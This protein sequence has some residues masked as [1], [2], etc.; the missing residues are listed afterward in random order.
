MRELTEKNWTIQ[1]TEAIQFVITPPGFVNV[2]LLWEKYGIG[3]KVILSYV[4]D[5]YTHWFYWNHDLREISQYTFNLEMSQPGKI[6][7]IIN[8]WDNS[9]KK[10][11][12]HT[13]KLSSINLQELTKDQLIEE[14]QKFSKSY[15]EAWGE[16]LSADAISLYMEKILSKKLLPHLDKKG[17][18]YNYTKY[19]PTL[20]APT[21]TSFAA[22]E[23]EDLFKIALKSQRKEDIS[24]DLEEHSK[25][26][27]WLTNS[28]LRAVYLTPEF[29]KGKVEE[30]TRRNDLSEKLEQLHRS[31]LKAKEEK[32]KLC[33]ELELTKEII[34]TLNLIDL[35][36]LWQDKRKKN[37]LIG[38]HYQY[39]FFKELCRRNNYQEKEWGGLTSEEFVKA[40]NKEISLEEIKERS[41]E[42]LIIF[43]HKKDPIIFK[44]KEANTLFKKLFQEKDTNVNDVRGMCASQGRSEGNVK[45]ILKSEDLPKMQQ[46]DILISSM[47]RPELVPAMK[48]AAAIV[49][50]EGGITSHAAI[51][52]RE[53]GIPCVVG[54]KIATKVF[55]DN[56][57]IEVNANHGI[58]RKVIL[59]D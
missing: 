48:K 11:Q 5:E 22:Q 8:K 37:N 43:Q 14:Y 34:A 24:Q 4:K 30:L 16:S 13:H 51:V 45:I 59:D 53:L 6:N 54:T 28:Y 42:S 31:P 12:E 18:S 7:T 52:S 58:A 44:G 49:T 40:L 35:F 23:T 50:D 38:D 41:Q 3:Y 21:K 25:K 17:L 56:D 55:K 57:F 26:Y 46:G 15:A 19:L 39:F 9:S 32:A 1:A 33:K 2:N 20:T 27:F 47:T 29:F 10:F 36:T